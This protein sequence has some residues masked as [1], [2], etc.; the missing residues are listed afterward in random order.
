MSSLQQ[1]CRRGQNRFF[2]E[3]RGFKGSEGVRG[4][5]G[6]NNVCTCKSIKKWLKLL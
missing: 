2:L 5:N 1:N 4:R 6:P 3:A